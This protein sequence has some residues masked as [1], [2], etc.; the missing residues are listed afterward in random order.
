MCSGPHPT[1][2]CI[3]RHKVKEPTTAKCPNCGKKHHAWNPQCPE[4]RR[5]MRWPPQRQQHQQQHPRGGPQHQWRRDPPRGL[6]PGEQQRQHRFVPAPPPER[7]ALVSQVPPRESTPSQA[8]TGARQQPTGS[9][10]TAVTNPP[11]QPLPQRQNGAESRRRRRRPRNRET[12]PT[13]APAAPSAMPP[14]EVCTAPPA[15]MP[16]APSTASHAA[17]GRSTGALSEPAWPGG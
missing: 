5:R 10:A 4:R 16:T 7:S 2:E 13:N 8:S 14:M 17:S 3:G 12:Q 15:A 11:D 1:E 9:E 6:Q